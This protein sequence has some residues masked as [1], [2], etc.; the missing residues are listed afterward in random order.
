MNSRN[1]MKR[2]SAISLF[3][4][5]GGMD[6]GVTGAGFDVLA[7]FELDRH[8]CD[9][10]RT[11]IV[12]ENR[13]TKVF[14]GDVRNANPEEIRKEVGLVRGELA[15]LFGGPPCQPFSQIGKQGSLSDPRGLLIFELIRFAEA[16]RPKA[17]LFEQVKGLMTAPDQ[18]GRRGGVFDL[19]LSKLEDIDYVPKWRV[20]KAAD[21][22][23]PQLRERVF[24][25]ATEK[26][27]GFEFPSPTHGPEDRVDSLFPLMPYVT[28][29]EAI[30]DLGKPGKK[31]K[32]GKLREDSHVDVT[33]KREIERMQGV[34]EGSYLGA[35]LHLPKDQVMNL[36]LKDST[37][38]RRLARNKASNTL[39]CGE[40]FFH[41][42]KDRYL[43]PREYLR[44]HGY[45]DSYVL[46][47]P[48]RR[49]T[50]TVR[51]LDQHRQVANSVPP[52]VARA[53]AQ[54]IVKVITCR[55]STN[56]LVTA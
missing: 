4:G 1:V 25:V 31:I 43:T 15:L 21:F 29:D 38:F 26:P 44:L 16:L 24:I 9:T 48:I 54:Q 39:R 37:K 8:C 45:P 14:E 18:K 40:I 3:T 2:M 13:R 52:P 23:V 46:K 27:N 19:V 56:S 7:C 22:G 28:V 42:I 50:G 32:S 34:P 20:I 33:P 51:D 6:I 12:R 5:A 47:G 35:Q 53:I 36:K 30:R 11:N 10:L 41:P 55:K 17:I 49:R